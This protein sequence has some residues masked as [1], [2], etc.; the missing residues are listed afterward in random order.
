MST[1]LLVCHGDSIAS[2]MLGTAIPVIQE[3]YEAGTNSS[4]VK[5]AEVICFS[6]VAIVAICVVGFL[7]W[8]QLEFHARKKERE[9]YKTK[10]EEESVRK[11]KADLLNKKLVALSHDTN[12]YLKALEEAIQ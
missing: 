10:E 6:L 5:I 8:K 1:I 2:T 9:F 4:D 11:Q 7:V 12:A 3:T